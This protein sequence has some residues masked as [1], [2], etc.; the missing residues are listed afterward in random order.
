[1]I[2]LIAVLVLMTGCATECLQQQE[3]N[4]DHDPTAWRKQFEECKDKFYTHYPDEIV[5]TDWHKCMSKNNSR[6]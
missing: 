5:E 3:Q 1:M 4:D 6:L 2:K